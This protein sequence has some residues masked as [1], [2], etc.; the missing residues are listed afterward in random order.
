MDH[1]QIEQ[2]LR[3]TLQDYRLSRGER[4][5]LS[6]VIDQIGA[7]EQA[8]GYLRSRAFALA[9][10]QL[11]DPESKAVLDWLEDVI[12]VLRTRP[13]S[14]PLPDEVYFSP[15]ER[16]PRRIVHLFEGTE[17]KADVCV[18]T[19]TDDRIADAIRAAFRRGVELRIITDDDKSSDAGSDIDSLVREG[20]PV[21]KDR[22]EYHMHHK[23]A[24]FDDRRT[25]TGSYNWTRSAAQFNEENFLVTYDPDITRA[26]A[27]QFQRIWQSLE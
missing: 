1:Q 10:E 22:S 19:I 17:Q 26:F 9:G 8:L 25:L 24:I 20:V 5:V 11:L 7:D 23:F 2:I 4:R 15:D 13:A 18:F 14:T 27:E 12:K 16:C 6:D 3:H 21:R